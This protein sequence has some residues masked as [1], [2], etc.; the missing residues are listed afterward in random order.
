MHRMWSNFSSPYPEKFHKNRSLAKKISE[1]TLTTLNQ[2][3][4]SRKAMPEIVMYCKNG[5]RMIQ[6]VGES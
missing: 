1:N 5:A 3:S 6:D 4:I 2:K